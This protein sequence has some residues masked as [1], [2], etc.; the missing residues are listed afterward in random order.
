MSINNYRMVGN[1][2]VL[3]LLYLFSKQSQ[4][5]FQSNNSK[6]KILQLNLSKKKK[7]LH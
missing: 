6:N 4:I 3:K 7:N 5:S 2:F 1:T